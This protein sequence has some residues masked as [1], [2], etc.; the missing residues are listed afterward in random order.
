MDGAGWRLLGKDQPTSWHISSRSN[1]L[2][3]ERLLVPHWV[4]G[5]GRGGPLGAIFLLGV[6][7]EPDDFHLHARLHALVG[8]ELA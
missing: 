7:R 8:Q 4:D 6:A 1:L 2:E 3:N 5:V